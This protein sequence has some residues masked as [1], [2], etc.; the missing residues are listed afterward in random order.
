MVAL[1]VIAFV[2]WVLGLWV[3]LQ[4]IASG[5]EAVPDLGSMSDDQIAE[6][7]IG[8][9]TPLVAAANYS[10]LLACIAAIAMREAGL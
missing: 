7:A 5:R 8:V 3:A 6:W 4:A 2:A 10:I 9:L 1:C